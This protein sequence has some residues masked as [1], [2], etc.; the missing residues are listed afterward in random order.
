[1]SA[2]KNAK[3]EVPTKVVDDK[4]RALIAKREKEE[5]LFSLYRS[6]VRLAPRYRT[7]Y[8]LNVVTTTTTLS[9]DDHRR[10]IPSIQLLAK[11]IVAVLQDIHEPDAPLDGKQIQDTEEEFRSHCRVL[12]HMCSVTCTLTH[13]SQYGDDTDGCRHYVDLAELLLLQ[14]MQLVQDRFLL[15]KS[16]RHWNNS[17]AKV[18]VPP[19]SHTVHGD[20]DEPHN[21][22]L[23]D[24]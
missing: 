1:M 12:Q 5:Q 11:R 13:L 2:Y 16:A 4:Q 6:L 24:G 14:T 8:R 10:G 21:P 18:V 22:L 9:S 15:I 3:P 23:P 20:D 19:G 7:R 17:T